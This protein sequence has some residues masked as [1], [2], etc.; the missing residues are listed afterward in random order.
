MKEPFFVGK[1]NNDQLVRIAKVLGTDLLY[2]YLD[3]Y[4]TQ[5]DSD[6]EGLLG[7]YAPTSTHRTTHPA[8][9]TPHR[10]RATRVDCAVL[11][12]PPRAAAAA[13]ATRAS[14]GGS[15]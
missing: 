4:D 12:L 3:K 8:P 6:F 7:E 15:L 11:L 13:A 10:A 2:S 5:L 1:D 14:R 9:R